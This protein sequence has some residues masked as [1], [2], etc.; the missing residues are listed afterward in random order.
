MRG[1][2]LAVSIKSTTLGTTSSNVG[3][4]GQNYSK[5]NGVK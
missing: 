4:D 2:K 1:S 3:G 5:M